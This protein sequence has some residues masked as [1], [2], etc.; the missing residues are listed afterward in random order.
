MEY[1]KILAWQQT[2]HD[3]KRGVDFPKDKAS[4]KTAE[5]NNIVIDLVYSK[6][7]KQV[8]T[9]VMKER[10]LKFP[11]TFE[12]EEDVDCFSKVVTYTRNDDTT[13]RKIKMTILSWHT[14]EQGKFESRSINDLVKDIYSTDETED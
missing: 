12:L 11:I 4:F 5:G 2:V 1:I 7:A 10:Q 14:V 13:G 8:L 9:D 6:E 3:E